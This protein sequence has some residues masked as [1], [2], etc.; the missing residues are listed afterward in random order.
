MNNLEFILIFLI[1]NLFINLFH[2]KI[3]KF[4]NVYDFPNKRKIHK[5]K[6]PLLGGYIVLFNILLFSFL[7]F[8]NLYNL[9]LIQHIFYSKFQF[10]IFLCATIL[11]FLV[12][13]IDDKKNLNPN[14]KLLILTIIVFVILFLDNS[15]IIT[16]LRFSFISQT[17]HLGKYS[18]IFTLLCFLLFIN[19]CNMF[20]GINLQSSSYFIILILSLIIFDIK[21]IF[22]IFLLCS[23]IFIFKLNINGK[24]FMGDSG[25]YIFS[26]VIA[27]LVIKNYNYNFTFSADKI[28]ILMMFPGIDMFRLFLFRIAKKKNPFFPDKNHLHHL[29]LNKFSYIFTILIINLLIIL[30]ILLSFLGIPNQYTILFSITLYIFIFLLLNKKI[31]ILN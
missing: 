5:I 23:L 28:F 18:F 14:Y 11:I 25:I 13:A 19:A 30:P 29:L 10:I 17:I 9:N 1:F 20:D 24:I 16:D 3:S 27:Y 6:T 31:K 8:T 12:G 7:I 21:N 4:I 22:L 15:L 26:L 2:N